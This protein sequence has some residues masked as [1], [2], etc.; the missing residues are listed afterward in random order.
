MNA[1][2]HPRALEFTSVVLMW[3]L[4]ATSG[5]GSNKPI[6]ADPQV[7]NMKAIGILYGKFI[8]SH[9]GR[10]PESE[11]E[12]LKYASTRERDLLREFKV[13]DAT[14]LLQPPRQGQSIVVVS[15]KGKMAGDNP[16]AAYEPQPV[17]GTRI[18][19]YTTGS[20]QELNEDQFRALVPNG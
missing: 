7:K 2:W 14:K 13:D 6:S 18:V 3:S 4:A 12:F 17:D 8:G 9:Q 20:V 15:G 1:N 5:C 11:Q 10:I 16:I 19:V